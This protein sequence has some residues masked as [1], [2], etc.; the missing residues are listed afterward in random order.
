MTAGSRV[1]LR[2]LS[3]GIDARQT[4]AE[5][6][7]LMRQL[8][9]DALPVLQ[10]RRPTAAITRELLERAVRHGQH[11]LRVQQM[12]VGA[13]P[14][15]GA[16][17]T[18][19]QLAA[20]LARED[21]PLVLVRG[22]RGTL[23]GF[24][25]RGELGLAPGEPPVAVLGPARLRALR[26]LLPAP[27]KRALRALVDSA[28]RSAGGTMLVGGTVRDLLLNRVP[29][30]L[31]VLVLGELAALA[32][33]LARRTRAELHE[34]GSFLTAEL[35]LPGG[36]RVDLSRARAE[37][38]RHPG[39]LP[40]VRPGS[41]RQDLARRDFTVNALALQLS[42]TGFSRLFDA[43]G[44]LQD[45]RGRRL[46]ALHGLSFIED[47]TRAL[48]AA[49]LAARLGLT[50]EP[51]TLALMR[52]AAELG[53]LERVSG[54]RLRRELERLLGGAAAGRG[55]RLL[56][57]SG[58]LG[59]LH[60]ALRPTRASWQH[61]ARAER[62]LSWYRRRAQA[63]P[64]LEWVVRLGALLSPRTTAEVGSVLAR[65]QPDAKAGKL[66]LAA[67]PAVRELLAALR[68]SR[69]PAAAYRACRGRPAEHLLLALS[70]APARGPARRALLHY[71]TK[72]HG[73]RA[74][75]SGRDLVRAGV[76]PG[77]AVARGLEAALLA[78]LAGVAP[79][80]ASQLRAALHAIAGQGDPP[81]FSSEA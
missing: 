17:T 66:L 24:V 58:L 33:R 64:L 13:L 22:A 23:L 43:Y 68:R 18:R 42:A 67:A 80:R 31:D 8:G 52:T 35:R 16:R 19:A 5:A 70:A 60:P 41:L 77:P 10:A 73:R 29:Q 72:M 65:L 9:A 59:A 49:S 61:L 6:L 54:A 48:R 53:V 57:R 20:T 27:E 30:D 38:Y 63:E 7:A 34:H 25:T 55:L 36:L 47:P 2:P 15:V 11:E 71:L 14:R 74:D 50:I 12:L 51:R 44:G 79:S 76:R 39:A 21:H 40:E 78:K 56:G 75:I 69:Q 28:G 3:H 62:C 4:A 81:D 1:P 26:A 37:H 32:E 45:L 46:R